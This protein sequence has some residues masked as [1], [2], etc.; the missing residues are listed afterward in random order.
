MKPAH[1]TTPATLGHDGHVPGLVGSMRAKRP[2]RVIN[3]AMESSDD[4]RGAR[5]AAELVGW[6]IGRAD[7][8]GILGLPLRAGDGRLT[9]ARPASAHGGWSRRRPGAHMRSTIA[10]A[11]SLVRTWVAPSIWRAK[12]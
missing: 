9:V 8:V 11:N 2:E 1:A 10:S 7:I 4:K 12:S 6:S 5:R 3:P